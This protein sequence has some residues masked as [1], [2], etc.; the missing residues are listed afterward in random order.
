MA[1]HWFVVPGTRVRF[2]LLAQKNAL[3][4]QWIEHLASDQGVVGST[5]AERTLCGRPRIPG[6]IPSESIESKN[7]CLSGIFVTFI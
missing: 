4:A 6:S 3:V 1:E 7:P 2:P 5:P